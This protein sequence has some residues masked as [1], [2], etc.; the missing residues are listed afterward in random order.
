M[1]TVR[2]TRIVTDP[3]HGTFGVLTIDGV[4]FCVTLE[5]YQ[6]DNQANISCIP[7]SQY[8]VIPVNSAKFGE[9][10][11]LCSVPGRGG[12]LIHA[13][14]IDDH[15]EGCIIV[16]EHFGKLGDARAVLNSGKTFDKFN[17]II[18]REEFHLTIVEAY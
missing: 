15:S 11:R 4:A 1:K 18:D 2:I 9:T 17:E 7:A 13:G 10:Y 5:P 12:I 8:H 16:A 6:M 14:N 3:N